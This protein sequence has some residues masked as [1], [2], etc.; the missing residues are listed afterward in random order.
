MK[1]KILLAL[2][3]G[4]AFSGAS[5]SV[6]ADSNQDCD[7]RFAIIGPGFNQLNTNAT[8]NYIGAVSPNRLLIAGNVNG[9]KVTGYMDLVGFTASGSW[10][11]EAGAAGGGGGI[12]SIEVRDKV[13]IV[14][15]QVRQGG[16][17]GPIGYR[18]AQIQFAGDVSFSGGSAGSSGIS[19]INYI[20][21]W[22]SN[23]TNPNKG[24]LLG[25]TVFDNRGLP[26][27]SFHSPSAMLC[28]PAAAGKK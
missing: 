21:P 5:P 28:K 11:D 25:G 6:L 9:Y 22:P 19:K 16:P 23:V 17:W 15:G 4:A 12:T 27:G 1:S 10:G 26:S 3:A 8:I 24:L 18:T 7:T 14:S 13:M 20:I 2:A